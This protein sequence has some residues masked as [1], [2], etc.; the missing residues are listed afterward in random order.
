M[1]EEEFEKTMYVKFDQNNGSVLGVSPRMF[2]D[3]NVI[4]VS[5]SDA[6]PIIKGLRKRKDYKVEFDSTTQN[7]Q[8]IYKPTQVIENFKITKSIYEVPRKGVVD[9]DIHVVQDLPYTCWKV[10]VSQKIMKEVDHFRS[11]INDV[12]EFAITKKHDPNIL[13]RNLEVDVQT[14]LQQSYV[15]KEFEYDFEF[16]SRFDLSIF[17]S[18]KFETYLYERRIKNEQ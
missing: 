18:K 14:L 11:R 13:Y 10:F 8:L 9:P 1:P 17:T 16:D 5:F 2:D 7:F 12:H 4:P 15:I 3:G 6:R